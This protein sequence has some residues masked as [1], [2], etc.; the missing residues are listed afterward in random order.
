MTITA[1]IAAV[2]GGLVA[3]FK[4][5]PIVNSWVQTFVVWYVNSQIDAMKAEDVAALKKAVIEKDQRDLEKAIGNPN[6]GG[7]SGIPGVEHRDTLPG[8]PRS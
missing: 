3:F 7:A 6:A 4:A 2:F 1:G 5:I 8:V